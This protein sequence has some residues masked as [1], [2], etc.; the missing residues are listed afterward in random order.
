MNNP[1]MVSYIENQIVENETA[2]DLIDHLNLLFSVREDIIN[3]LESIESIIM[4]VI[5]EAE[6][7]GVEF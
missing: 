1:S 5:N 6:T 2:G 7:L 3:N 4:E